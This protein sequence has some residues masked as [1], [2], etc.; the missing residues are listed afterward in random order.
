MLLVVVV[1]FV[2]GVLL[3]AALPGGGSVT[4]PAAPAWVRPVAV[5]STVEPA[6]GPP[7]S[8]RRQQLL[9]N[10]LIVAGATG[11]AVSATGM[12]IVARWRRR[13]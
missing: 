12:V 7:P 6:A 11:L 13:W 1:T 8:G 4:R 10:V 2:L 3:G 9:A 5:A